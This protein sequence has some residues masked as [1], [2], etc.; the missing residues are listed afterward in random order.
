M[1]AI[2]DMSSR[3]SPLL[4]DEF[5]KPVIKATERP[6][7]ACVYHRCEIE[8]ALG[9]NPCAII[10]CGTALMDFGYVNDEGLRDSLRDLDSPTLGI[11][12]GMHAIALARGSRPYECAEIGMS[13]IKTE[14][15]NPLFSGL[16][17]AYSMH[18]L[19]VDV[20]ASLTLIASS[21][22][23]PQAFWDRGMVFGVLFHPEA[24]NPQI[25]KRFID[26]ALDYS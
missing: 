22:R 10:L 6:D 20:P 19:A 11:C 16:F 7:I 12:A 18:K 13:E 9:Q 3:I 4:T 21:K 15:E 1:I 14:N 25:I 17:K 8:D 2:I 23:C 5:I 26:L 24:R